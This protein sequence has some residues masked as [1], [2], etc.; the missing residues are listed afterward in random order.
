MTAIEK[1]EI[2][3]SYLEGQIALKDISISSGQAIRTLRRWIKQYR[4]DGLNGLER[5]KRSDQ[6]VLSGYV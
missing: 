5:K 1:F 6:E 2:I 4:A 3:E